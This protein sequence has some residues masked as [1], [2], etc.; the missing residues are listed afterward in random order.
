MS[1]QLTNRQEEAARLHANGQSKAEACREAGY[2]E[3][4]ATKA[5]SRVFAKPVMLEAVARF[6]EQLFE[7]LEKKGMT[8]ERIAGALAQQ[9]D[10]DP[11]PT[12]ALWVKI[13]AP[14]ERAQFQQDLN[15]MLEEY[16]SIINEELGKVIPSVA[17]GKKYEFFDS[18]EKRIRDKTKE[19]NKVLRV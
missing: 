11:L 13:V 14:N 2:S 19:W 4:T 6:R 18:L 12:I 15:E 16:I 10:V 7:Q 8:P 9:L 5:Q 17:D 3:T 1:E